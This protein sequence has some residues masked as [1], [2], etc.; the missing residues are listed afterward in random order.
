MQVSMFIPTFSL[1]NPTIWRLADSAAVAV[2]AAA[3]VRGIVEGDGDACDSADEITRLADAGK[4]IPRLSSGTSISA[5]VYKSAV[6]DV[7]VTPCR[8]QARAA[9]MTS[10]FY[11]V[12]FSA[13]SDP[14]TDRNLPPLPPHP[15][16]CCCSIFSL[17]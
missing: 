8:L 6:D 14:K 15:H 13:Q 5:I 10:S 12:M 11:S 7:R 16:S 4:M 2:C 3:L 1:P 9:C 17:Q